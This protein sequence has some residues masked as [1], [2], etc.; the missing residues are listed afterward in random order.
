MAIDGI[1]YAINTS[2]VNND[3]LL[4]YYDFTSGTGTPLDF[5]DGVEA[6]VKN[7][8]PASNTGVFTGIIVDSTAG[9]ESAA[10][11]FA[12]GT[13]LIKKRD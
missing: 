6:V 4:A 11:T 3:N 10:R 5:T 12:T 1:R 2:F 9:T 8:N 7:Q 13:F